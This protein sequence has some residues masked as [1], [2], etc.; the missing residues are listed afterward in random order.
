MSLIKN[1]SLKKYLAFLTSCLNQLKRIE[2]LNKEILNLVENQMN[3][4]NCFFYV[5]CRS[6]NL[7]E[8]SELILIL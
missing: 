4:N 2:K 5:M 8:W 1:L 7:Y 6:L 3:V